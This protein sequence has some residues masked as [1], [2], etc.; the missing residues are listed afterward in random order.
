MVRFENQFHFTYSHASENQLDRV[1]DQIATVLRTW[2][3]LPQVKRYL[4]IRT[5][6]KENKINYSVDINPIFDKMHNIFLIDVDLI[7]DSDEDATAFKLRW[8]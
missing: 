1:R 7:F 8:L 2:D 4:E 6:C 5:W 3:H